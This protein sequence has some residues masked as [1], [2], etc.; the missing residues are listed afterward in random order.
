MLSDNWAETALKRM[1]L[2]FINSIHWWVSPSSLLPVIPGLYVKNSPDVIPRPLRVVPTHS[3]P[4]AHPAQQQCAETGA[5]NPSWLQAS[6]CHS[7]L[8]VSLF[9]VITKSSLPLY[10][11]AWNYPQVKLIILPSELETPVS[12]IT[13]K[14]WLGVRIMEQASLSLGFLGYP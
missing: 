7:R 2:S 11:E 3:S 14:L 12:T 9:Q 10:W 13:G 1:P 4:C 6:F 8:L 5:L